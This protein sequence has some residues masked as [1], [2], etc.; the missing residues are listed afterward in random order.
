MCHIDGG[1]SVN[2]TIR[3]FRTISYKMCGKKSIFRK[4]TESSAI[5]PF[6]TSSNP[7]LVALKKLING[8]DCLPFP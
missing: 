7:L 5:R 3:F 2:V 1:G 8:G 6:R 4:H